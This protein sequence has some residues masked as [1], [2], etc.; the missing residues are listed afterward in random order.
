MTSPEGLALR[1]AFAFLGIG[2]FQVKMKQNLGRGIT[3]V[4][5]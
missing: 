1:A 4:M 2:A 5:N 3:W